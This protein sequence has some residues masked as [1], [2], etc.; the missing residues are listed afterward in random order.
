MAD[1]A[2][3][4]RRIANLARRSKT[5]PGNHLSGEKSSAEISR[6]HAA[7]GAGQPRSVLV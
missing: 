1:V 6:N 4:L 7:E 5:F 3:K 2:S